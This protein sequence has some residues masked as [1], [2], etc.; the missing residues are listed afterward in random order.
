MERARRG[1]RGSRGEER[2][3]NEVDAAIARGVFGSPFFVVDGAPF[4]GVD[5]M[6]MVEEWIRRGGW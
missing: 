2:R 3:P 6:P 1:A 5:R 4:W